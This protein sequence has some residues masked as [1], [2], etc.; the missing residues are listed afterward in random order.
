MGAD[1]S[2][3][4]VVVAAPNS[5]PTL[6]VAYFFS[7]VK[8][9][10]SIGEHFSSYCAAYEYDLILHDIDIVVGGSDHDLIVEESQGKWING[11][12][13]GD[14]GVTIFTPPVCLLEPC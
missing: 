1:V 10:A 12:E 2:R 7:G 6:R 11:I 13:N 9:K 5:G 14:F 4:T 3:K 8:R